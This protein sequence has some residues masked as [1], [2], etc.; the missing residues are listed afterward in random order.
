MFT[1]PGGFFQPK[2]D[3]N[4][5]SPPCPGEKLVRKDASGLK[6]Q[7]K[8][9]TT[10]P[11]SKR[12]LTPNLP[13]FY[14]RF[15][16]LGAEYLGK[17]EGKRHGRHRQ[18]LRQEAGVR[19]SDPPGTLSNVRPSRG[20]S[21]AGGSGDRG[22]PGRAAP[23]GRAGSRCRCRCRCSGSDRPAPGLS[24]A[25]PRAAGR[26]AQARRGRSGPHAAAGGAVRAP[27][28]PAPPPPACPGAAALWRRAAGPRR[29][30][31]APTHDQVRGSEQAGPGR[32]AQGPSRFPP[33]AACSG[34]GANRS[35]APARPPRCSRRAAR[36]GPALPWPPGRLSSAAGCL[37][38]L[39]GGEVV[40]TAA[41]C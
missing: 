28:G 27:R 5:S 6:Q 37:Q 33:S 1:S 29:A 3:T 39:A 14:R 17:P 34:F 21:L 11:P 12:K 35:P 4:P 7:Q 10:S 26:R 31:A 9:Q 16:T 15:P 2:E 24:R 8:N 23:A 40:A 22:A 38:G 20:R 30:M 41:W 36:P 13:A 19:G 25:P 18:P 32:A